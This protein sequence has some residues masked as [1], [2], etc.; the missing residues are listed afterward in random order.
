MKNQ[1]FLII[2]FLLALLGLILYPV[3]IIPLKGMVTQIISPVSAGV[4]DF[5]QGTKNFFSNI[6][7]I[8]ILTKANQELKAEN[9]A[10]KS[11]N[12]Q[13]SEISHQNQI[14]KEELGFSQEERSEELIPAAIIGRSPSGFVQVLKINKGSDDGVKD[15]QP[16]ISHGYLI[17]VTSQT[18][19]NNSEVFLITNTRSLVPIILQDS[20]GTGLLKGGLE[21]LIAR[22][23][24]VDSE[25]KIGESVLTSGL[26]GDLPAGIPVG[27]V[28][29]I[30][31]KES[32]IFQQVTVDSPVNIGKL[33]VVFIYQ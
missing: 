4:S 7:Q 8:N 17:G 13:C 25:I 31:S 28:T 23:I 14:L 12:S 11:T 15:G 3:A 19:S 9:L 6:M 24:P 5:T 32:E 10:L 30:I 29:D 27:Q 2:V 1:K 18:T 22:E 16:V 20:R 21:G 26:G 33:E